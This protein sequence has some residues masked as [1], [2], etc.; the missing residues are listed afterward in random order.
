MMRGRRVAPPRLRPRLPGTRMSGTPDGRRASP[1]NDLTDPERLD[2]SGNA[3]LNGVPV[4]VTAAV[5]THPADPV[6]S[7]G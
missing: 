1:I 3:A 7:V 2:V 6:G 5:P 4:T